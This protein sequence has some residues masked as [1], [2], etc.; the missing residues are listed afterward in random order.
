MNNE[1]RLKAPNRF[2]KKYVEHRHFVASITYPPVRPF[3]DLDKLCV[4]EEFAVA[5]EHA[6]ELA[7]FEKVI[8][9]LNKLYDLVYGTPH[10]NNFLAM[11]MPKMTFVLAKTKSQR[12]RHAPV[13]ATKKKLE[14]SKA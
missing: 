14:K 9:T 13:K 5:V 11:L 7:Q 2:A 6:I 12:I 4:S 8:L 10:E 3:L 1:H